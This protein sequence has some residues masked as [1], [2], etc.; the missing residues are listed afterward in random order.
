MNKGF[1]RLIGIQIII[2]GLVLSVFEFLIENSEL[3]IGFGIITVIVS[4][5]LKK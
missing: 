4:V 3:V 2:V 1:I 5:F